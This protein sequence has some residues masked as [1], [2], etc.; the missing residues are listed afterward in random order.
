MAVDRT[1]TG[2]L[3][4]YQV[5]APTTWGVL[6][7][8]PVDG[9]D[10]G[11][12]RRAIAALAADLTTDAEAAARCEQHLL[13]AQPA[14]VAQGPLA[15]AA[16]VPDPV[17]GVPAGVLVIEHVVDDGVAA[18]ETF[19]A[20]LQDRRPRDGE[21]EL[22]FEI[23]RTRVPAGEAL[24]LNALGADEQGDLE[25]SVTYV[26]FPDTCRDA[27]SLTFATGELHLAAEMARDAAAVVETLTVTGREVPA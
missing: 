6:P 15:V 18:P 24:V 25:E 2:G 5:G 1:R 23:E 10:A 11:P 22:R 27:I 26:V 9:P 12:A 19:L 7:R 14:L 20:G 3:Q 16:W 13:L 4:G 17:S 21:Q 8:E